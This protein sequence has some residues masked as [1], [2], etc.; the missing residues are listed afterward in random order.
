[1][2]LHARQVFGQHPVIVRVDDDEHVAYLLDYLLERNG[3]IVISASDGQELVDLLD[4]APAPDLILLDVM[5]PYYDGFE[6]IKRI[7]ANPVW[8]N[9]PILVL[10]GCQNEKDVVR[11]LEAGANDYITK[12]FQPMELLAR[13]KRLLGSANVSVDTE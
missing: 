1:M 11:G 3:C 7:R 5:L 2:N 12:P 13:I 8:K 6:L 10:S 9:T 4:R